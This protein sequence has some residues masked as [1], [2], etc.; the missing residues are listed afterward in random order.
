MATAADVLNRLAP[1]GVDCMDATRWAESLPD[2]SVHAIVTSPPYFALRDYGVAGQM[3][4]EASPAEYVAGMVRL[5]RELRRALHPSGTCWVNIGDSYN[6]FN[7]NRGASKSLSAKTDE[8]VPTV[9]GGSGLTVKGLK[10]KDRLM[11]P[12]RLALGLQE[13]GW[14]LRDEIVWHKPAPMPSSVRDRTT[15]AHEMIYLLTKSPRYFYDAEAIA[16]KASSFQRQDS[17]RGDR[18]EDSLEMAAGGVMRGKAVKDCYEYPTRNKRSVWRVTSKPF[19]GAHF[20]TFPPKLILPCVLAGTSERGVCP[21]CG[22]PWARVVKKDRKATRPG[23]ET[24]VTAKIVSHEENRKA[25]GWN[26]PSG[27]G[28]RD[29]KR[30]CTVTETV[31]WAAGCECD[32]GEPIPAVVCEPFVGSGTTLA[33]AVERKRRAVGCELNPKYLPLIERRMAGVT[34]NLF[35]VV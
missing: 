15:C 25:M 11:I 31:G 13:D 9:P 1:W 28:N 10:N 4:L 8:A 26:K 20:A 3:G 29:P 35:A 7:G 19:K 18:R 34:P 12:A 33:V 2:N 23:A 27:V 17:L 5:L 14:Y 30:H 6:A 22:E 21:A 16:E 32:A 24:K